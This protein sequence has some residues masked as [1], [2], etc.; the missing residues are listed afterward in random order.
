[1]AEYKVIQDI[2]AEDKL[3]GPLTLKQ[4]IFAG[5]AAGSAFLAFIIASRT[6]L[7]AFIPFLPLIIIPGVLAAPLGR[8]QPTDIWLAARI[9]FFIKPRKRIWDQ[10]GL[11]NLV[12]I[13]APKKVE[14]FY[15]NNLSQ[16][17]VRSRLKTLAETIDSHGWAVKNTD[18]NYYIAPTYSNAETD[19]LID[20]TNLPQIVPEVDISAADDIMDAT[21]NP[22]AQHFDEMVK[23]STKAHREAAIARMRQLKERSEQNLIDPD[24]VMFKP[25]VVVPVDEDAP[26]DSFLT[27]NSAPASAEELALLEKIKAQ[28]LQFDEAAKMMIPRHKIIKTPEEIAAEAA[29]IAEVEKSK[30]AQAQAVTPLKNPVIVNLATDKV[31]TDGMSIKTIAGLAN[32][33]IQNTNGE[34]VINLHGGGAPNI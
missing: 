8:D 17:E 7:L 32:R 15:S 21:S 23:E 3:L 30:V 34:V 20:P 5:I 2:E 33:P 29:A 11:K 1:M 26:K 16:Q 28:K 27:E 6:N 12:T 25:Q 24:S 14:R 4:F 9:R 13:T 18:L 31:A 19:R 10:N 22:I